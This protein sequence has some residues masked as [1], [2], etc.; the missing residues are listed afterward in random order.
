MKKILICGFCTQDIISGE[1]YLGGAAGGIALNL[2]AFQIPVG[3][4]SVLGTDVF[5]K[6]YIK[7]L[8]LRNVDTALVTTSIRRLPQMRVI[9]DNDHEEGRKFNDFG[10]KVILSQYKPNLEK[11]HE[12]DFLHIVNTPKLLCDY[13]AGN[14]SGEISYCPG[15]LLVREL[16]SLSIFLLQKT[17]YIF[18]NEQEFEILQNSCNVQN[19][20]ARNLKMI[21]VTKAKAGLDLYTN[22]SKIHI[23]SLLTT[24]LDTTGAG[25]AV[26]VGFIKSIYQNLSVESALEEGITLATQVIQKKGTLLPKKS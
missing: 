25:D 3:L 2:A 1:E 17:N 16:D 6:K 5:S 8:T 19:L 11:L 23:P 14:F 4:I 24:P 20:F 9:E 21:C 10:N 15:A 26:V 7:E 13:L 12:Y 22:G 18:C